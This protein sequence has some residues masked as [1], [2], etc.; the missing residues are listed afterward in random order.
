MKIYV[1]SPNYRHTSGG[2]K[3]LHYAIYLLLRLGHEVTTN[4]DTLNP[5]YELKPKQGIFTPGLYDFAIVPEVTD[6]YALHILGKPILR[7]ALFYPGRLGGPSFYSANEEVYFWHDRWGKAAIE[8]SH[9]QRASKW[10]LGMIDRTEYVFDKVPRKG[11]LLFVYKGVNEGTHPAN[12]YEITRTVTPTRES[13]LTLLRSYETLYSY[14]RNTIL[15]T[16]AYLMGMKVLQWNYER[17]EWEGFTP[18]EDEAK[19]IDYDKDGEHTRQ[20]MADFCEKR[21]IK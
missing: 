6:I 10:N 18:C 1:I 2:I 11:N 4:A 14:D 16:E 17:K 19:F 15:L 20:V 13:L 3:A 9:Y 5:A 21:G 8:A 7:W 12:C